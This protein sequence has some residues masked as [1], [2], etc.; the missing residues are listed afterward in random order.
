MN[1]SKIKTKTKQKKK[2]KIMATWNKTK[3]FA[4]KQQNIRK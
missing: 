3:Q 1:F 2:N 4:Q